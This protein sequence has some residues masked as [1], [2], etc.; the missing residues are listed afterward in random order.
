MLVRKEAMP[1]G[2]GGKRSSLS[3]LST[4]RDE[5]AVHA[6]AI[7]L[8]ESRSASHARKSWR[9]TSASYLSACHRRSRF[10]HN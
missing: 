7:G 8:S 10:S 3:G 5:S 2:E 1:G 4:I 6:F 9:T